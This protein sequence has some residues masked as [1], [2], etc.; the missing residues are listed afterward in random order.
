MTDKIE[1]ITEIEIDDEDELAV[2]LKIKVPPI[3]S[4]GKKTKLVPWIKDNYDALHKNQDTLYV[5]PFVGT[6]VVGFNLSPEKA[7]F[8]DINPH[9]INFYNGLK[10]K[11][12]D[13]KDVREF[14]EREGALLSIHGVEHYKE[15]RSRFNDFADP[16]DFLFLSRSCFNG[17]MRFN[18]KGGFNVPFC[19][20]PD[21]FAKAY[22]TKIVNEV[23]WLEFKLNT[24]DW[25]F[26]T[27]DFKD[28]LKRIEDNENVIVYSDGPYPSRYNDY[29]N[30]WSD[31]DERA[32]F[33]SLDK[34][35]GQ[36]IL[37]TWFGNEFRENTFITELW[38]K[39]EIVT[40]DHTYHL[41]AKIENRNEIKEAL[42]IKRN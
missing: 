40:K 10:Y 30:G 7:L 19:K 28:V 11:K 21:R 22:I 35:Q 26:E 15:I 23:K 1:E 38:S 3:K 37:S 17:M 33:T 41:G 5:E 13:H 32:L 18:K 36:F 24:N 4:Q 31:T 14:L 2:K 29:F 9:L 39:F 6:G 20:K 34:I 8:T 16:L 42:V 25:K 12:F 27:A